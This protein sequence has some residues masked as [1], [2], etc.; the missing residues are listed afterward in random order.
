MIRSIS[1]FVPEGAEAGVGLNLQDDSGRYL[2]FL[3]GTRENCPPGE[4]FY[5]GIGGHLEAGENWLGCAHREAI[6][7]I[8]T[9]V[10]ILPSSITWYV[11]KHG[12]VQQV[13]LTDIPRP[14][15][16]YKMLHPPGTPSEG[17][18]YRIVI[19]KA[20]LGVNRIGEIP[21]DELQGV[22]ALTKEQLIRG[23]ERRPSLADLYGEGASLIAGGDNLDNQICVYPIGTA[24]ALAHILLHINEVS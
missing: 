14:Y 16:I 6:E 5:G 23:L 2:F 22:I 19:Y 3:A 7:E 9:D 4:L 8:G 11:T 15:A 13:E 21:P 1:D 18:V 20:C 17:N 24:A 12:Q 10:E